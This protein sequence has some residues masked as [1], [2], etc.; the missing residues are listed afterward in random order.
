MNNSVL[1]CD[2]SNKAPR[3][4]TKSNGVEVVVLQ[5]LECGRYIREVRKA[6]YDLLKVPVFDYDLRD[7]VVAE[8]NRYWNEV[9]QQKRAESDAKESEWW[10][11]Y[12]R[13]LSTAHWKQVRRRVLVRDNFQCQSCFCT[14]TD[15]SAHVHHL[16]YD[17]YKNTGKSY[18]FE[19]V[20]LCRKCHA[21]YH[22]EMEVAA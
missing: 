14:V 1:S 9:H 20:T 11:G 16:S 2:C 6:D 13:Y 4:Y 8:R 22:S 10:R 18:A 21:E 7:R 17:G 19:C 5:C 15:F 12:N 3:I